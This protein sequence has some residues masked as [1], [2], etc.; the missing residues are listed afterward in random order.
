MHTTKPFYAMRLLCV[1]A[2]LMFS[3]SAQGAMP[4]DSLAHHLALAKQHKKELNYEKAYAI[5]NQLACA[6]PHNV[7]YMLPC[8]ELQVL[9]GRE[10]EAVKTYREI[11]E[12]APDNLAA[13]L[14]LGNY[15][16]LKAELRRTRL[17]K[18]FNES[19][20]PTKVRNEEYKKKMN[21]IFITDYSTAGKHLQNVLNVFPSAEARKTMEKIALVEEFV[22]GK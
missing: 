15:Y 9:L 7:D 18:E 19:A 4:T 10:E 12:I 22:K 13:N 20:Q 14:Y 6:H 11:L 1:I 21:L 3:A 2:V 17:E 16:Y 5:Y 8:A